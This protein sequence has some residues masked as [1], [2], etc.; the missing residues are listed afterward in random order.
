MHTVQGQVH[1]HKEE[2]GLPCIDLEQLDCMAT[3]MLMQNASQQMTG[4]KV[5]ALVQTVR[6]NYQVYTKRE[7]LRA[8]EARCAQAMIGNPSKGDCKGMVS[9]NMIKNCLIT[10]FDTAYAKEIFGPALANVQGKTVCRTPVPV[11]GDYVAVPHS[12]VE[13]NEIIIMVVDMFLG[14]GTAFLFMLSKNL[15]FIRTEHTPVQTTK[16]L[17]KHIEQVLQVYQRTD[18]IIRTILMD[19][20]FE[21]IKDILPTVECYT[22]AANEHVSKAERTIR[23]VKE[24]TRGLVCTLPFTHIPQ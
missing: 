23:T 14:D 5:V 3:I 8:K 2:Q 10:P 19:G 4:S 20:E 6:E 18:F 15:K 24:R 22:T 11:V 12:L 17:V 13:Q 21:K 7:M 9:S 16:A 1:F